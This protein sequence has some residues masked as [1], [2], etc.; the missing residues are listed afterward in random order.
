[1]VQ[2]V[3]SRSVRLFLIGE[4]TF[5]TVRSTCERMSEFNRLANPKENC[6]LAHDSTAKAREFGTDQIYFFWP[7][8]L[9]GIHTDRA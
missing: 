1:M 9:P 5:D 2:S 8:Q 3:V 6:G 7:G 4:G